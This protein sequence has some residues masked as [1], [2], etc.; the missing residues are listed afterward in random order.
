MTGVDLESDVTDQSSARE[1]VPVVPGL[2]YGN[3]YTDV[4]ERI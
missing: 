2:D 3:Y 1:V 4:L